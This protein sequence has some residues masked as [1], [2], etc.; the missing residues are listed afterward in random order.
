MIVLFGFLTCGLGTYEAIDAIVQV[1]RAIIFAFYFCPLLYLTFFLFSC[2]STL[3][4][5]C[6]V[7]F[8]SL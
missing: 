2:F 6:D 4:L 1:V 7:E 5:S 3:P 8:Q